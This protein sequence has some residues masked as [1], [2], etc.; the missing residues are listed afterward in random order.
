MKVPDLIFSQTNSELICNSKINDG[1]LNLD[2]TASIIL[3]Q[4]ATQ[5]DYSSHQ[6]IEFS[7]L[8]NTQ[9]INENFKQDNND[10]SF[11][12]ESMD[13]QFFSISESSSINFTNN[14]KPN[15][16]HSFNI[17]NILE[18]CAICKKFVF[19]SLNMDRYSNL[20]NHSCENLNE[21]KSFINKKKEKRSSQISCLKCFCYC[22]F[23]SLRSSRIFKMLNKKR[24][25]LE[26]FVDGKF[27][28]AIICAILIN[29]ISM[30]IEHHN[31]VIFLFLFRMCLIYP[32]NNRGFDRD[33]SIFNQ[34][35]PFLKIY[36][37][38]RKII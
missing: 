7:F 14:I 9:K 38:F 34:R 21:M 35:L 26:R 27:N 18:E 1:S 6:N 8:S 30:G 32:I 31:Q 29:T 33:Y 17:D 13:K 24:N 22:C 2:K 23:D 28:W 36:L 12:E 15:K 4:A 37:F 19:S 20:Q 10:K 25:S 3:K 16:P 11:N 5:N